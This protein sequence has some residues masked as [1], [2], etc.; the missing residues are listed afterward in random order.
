MNLR[1]KSELVLKSIQIIFV[2]LLASQIIFTEDKIKIQ[3]QT[4]DQHTYCS[5]IYYENFKRSCLDLLISK[6]EKNCAMYVGTFEE[7]SCQNEIK[8]LKQKRGQIPLF[9]YRMILTFIAILILASWYS[10]ILKINLGIEKLLSK[11]DETE[12]LTDGIFP[13]VGRTV[14]TLMILIGITFLLRNFVW[15]SIL[16]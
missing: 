4:L 1:P 2:F 9:P 12:F 15:P 16:R 11:N 5:T 3:K 14:I 13:I 7:K 6:K 10:N 8:I